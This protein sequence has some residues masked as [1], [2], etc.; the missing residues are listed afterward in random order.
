MRIQIYFSLQ[1]TYIKWEERNRGDVKIKN[2]KK[3]LKI[4]QIIVLCLHYTQTNENTI[5]ID[6]SIIRANHIKIMV[7]H[8]FL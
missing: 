1:K 8:Q 7:S 4:S 2:T 3:I 6:I 5:D